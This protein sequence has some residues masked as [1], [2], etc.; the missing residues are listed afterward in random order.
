MLLNIL[1]WTKR[2]AA[3]D[4]MELQNVLIRPQKRLPLRAPEKGSRLCRRSIRVY[5]LV[6]I[7]RNSYRVAALDEVPDFVV[8]TK[9]RQ[10]L[11]SEMSCTVRLPDRRPHPRVCQERGQ[12]SCLFRRGRSHRFLYMR[13]LDAILFLTSAEKISLTCGS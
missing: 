9:R 8:I 7:R 6:I 5:S 2:R 10:L 4:K 11:E 1:T 12:R 3:S 13:I